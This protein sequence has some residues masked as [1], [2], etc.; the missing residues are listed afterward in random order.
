MIG[1]GLLADQR[2][3]HKISYPK[4][5]DTGAVKWGYRQRKFLLA[6]ERK[7]TSAYQ[8]WQG[9]RDSLCLEWKH[10]LVA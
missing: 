5:D 1:I 7:E 3:A 9:I 4:Q 8:S 6:K 2:N 10:A